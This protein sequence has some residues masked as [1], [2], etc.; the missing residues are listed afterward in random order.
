MANLNS[1]YFFDLSTYSHKTL[2]A[3]C[4]YPWEIF[5]KISF[6]LKNAVLG[7]IQAEICSGSFLINPEMISIGKGTIVEPGAYIRGPCII[8]ENCQIRHGAYIRGDVI[9]GN[10]CVI[11]HDTEIKNS[12]MLNDAHAAHFAYVGDSILGNKVNL[13]AGVK[14]ANL[15]MNNSQIVIHD[16]GEKIKTNLRK[17]GA[18]IGDSSQIGC[19]AVANPGT[20]I[21]KNVCCYPCVNF[22]GVVPSRSTV[23]SNVRV[24]VTKNSP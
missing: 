6:Y 4:T 15:K 23:K 14:C 8:G 1:E 5:S 18:I 3:D 21:G 20:L 24:L 19:N 9:T 10:H 22:G 17:F 7:K 11:G 12:V 16:E 2:F 13:G